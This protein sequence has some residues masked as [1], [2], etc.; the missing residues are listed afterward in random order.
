M[1]V[2]RLM[3]SIVGDASGARRAF[4]E[5]EAGAGGLKRKLAG[6][7]GSLRSVGASMTANVTVPVVA[8][9]ALATKAAADE[10]Q[11]QALLARALRNTQHA[12]AGDIAAVEKWVTAT[13]NA[14]GVADGE[15][16][17]ALAKLLQ[18]GRTTAQAQRD[19]AV[20]LD[21]AAARGKPVKTV[22]EAMSKAA[23][24]NVGALGRLGLATK[25]AAGETL[26]YD[27]VLKRASQTM[28][29]SAAA[30]ADTAAGKS[31]IFHAQ[32]QDLVESI[33]QSL[34]PV[35]QDLAKWGGKLAEKFGN[36]SPNTRKVIVVA[37]LLVAALGPLALGLSAVATAVGLIASPVGLVVA[38]IAALTA[39]VIYAYTHWEGFR[40]AVD[41]VGRW[42][43]DVAWPAIQDFAVKVRQAFDVVVAWVHEHWPQIKA[44]VQAVVNAVVGYVR[45]WW[46]NL[47]TALAAMRALWDTFGGYITGAARIVWRGITATIGNALTYIRNVFKFWSAVFHGDWGRAWDAVRGALGAVWSQIKNLVR[48]G[49]EAIGNLFHNL[50]HIVGNVWGFLWRTF[51]SA[52]NHIV[53]AWNRLEFRV[54]GIHIPGLVN[55]PAVTI[56][57]PDIPRFHSGGTFR[58]ARPGGEGLAILRDRERIIPAGRDRGRAAGEGIVVGG[59]LIVQATGPSAREVVGELA[60][61]TRSAMGGTG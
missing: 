7:G 56:P 19:M 45:W 22:V 34:L 50:P 57:L 10:Q 14:T 28:G 12:R 6:I 26:T 30:A 11:E 52:L 35:M 27:Q 18:A 32:M 39:G 3:V 9:L 31:R 21:I 38:A 59:D 47:Q 58:A 8:G 51:R 43:R 2:K 60:F 61:S 17:P 23:L 13:Q 15:L 29:G 24:G 49:V 25:D 20:A 16:R 46:G 53:D 55:T 54:P 5:T 42:L 44:T 1:A 36:L 33:G 37:A 41:A 4:K 48:S 40:N